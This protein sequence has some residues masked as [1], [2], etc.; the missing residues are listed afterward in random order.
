MVVGYRE[1]LC[2]VEGEVG[3]IIIVVVRVFEKGD[4]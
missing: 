1:V 4:F 3:S 2:S